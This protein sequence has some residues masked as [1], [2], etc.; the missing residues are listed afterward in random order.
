MKRKTARFTYLVQLQ[1]L[2]QTQTLVQV[3]IL[4]QTQTLVP[5]RLG[6]G[7]DLVSVQTAN[8]LRLRYGGAGFFFRYSTS[9]FSICCI[10]ALRLNK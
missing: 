6:S 4:A 7:T 5:C 10:I 2:A 1:T 8:A 9:P 3:Q